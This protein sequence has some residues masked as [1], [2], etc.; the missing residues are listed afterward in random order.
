MDIEEC[1]GGVTEQLEANEIL[2]AE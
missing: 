1:D 2:E